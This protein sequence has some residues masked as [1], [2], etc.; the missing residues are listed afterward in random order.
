M[1]TGAAPGEVP[2]LR[3]LNPDGTPAN[4]DEEKQQQPGHEVNPDGQPVA[5]PAANTVEMDKEKAEMLLQV[6]VL[7]EGWCICYKSIEDAHAC[8]V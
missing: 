8:S 7:D 1:V 2:P 3:E 4:P 6:C 5:A